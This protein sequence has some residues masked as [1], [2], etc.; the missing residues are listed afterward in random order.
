[1]VIVGNFI[2]GFLI[3]IDV[4]GKSVFVINNKISNFENIGI[5]VY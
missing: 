4:R 3:G 2:I 1:M 5:L